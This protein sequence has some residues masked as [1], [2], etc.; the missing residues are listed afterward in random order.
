MT[1]VQIR[2][3]TSADIDA[4]TRIYAGKKA[5]TGTLGL[6]YPSLEV[7]QKK[8][9][10]MPQG[11]YSL[12]ADLNGE[13]VGNLF[14]GVEQNPRRKHVASFG[15]WVRDDLQGQQIGS[16]LMAAAIDLADN[17]LNVHRLEITVYT[18]NDAAIALYRKFGFEIEGEGKDFAFRDGSYANVFYMAR[19]RSAA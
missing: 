12:V 19:I 1:T 15:I 17:W 11:S 16:Q 14:L 10:T 2:H 13:V 7:W 9:G 5:Y 6:P 3:S 8:L 18:D 4:I